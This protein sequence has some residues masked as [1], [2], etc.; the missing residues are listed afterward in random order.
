LSSIAA[1]A[2]AAV[3]A[4]VSAA[5]PYLARL[6]LAADRTSGPAFAQILKRKKESATAV[7]AAAGGS[8]CAS[9]APARESNETG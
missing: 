5:S 9:R 4:I 7:D 3:G 1:G 6:D 8:V 2:G